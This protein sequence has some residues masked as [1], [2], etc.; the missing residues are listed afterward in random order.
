MFSNFKNIIDMVEKK[1]GA[2][3]ILCTESRF[4]KI[5]PIGTAYLVIIAGMK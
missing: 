4:K 3:T 5:V 2:R 1:K